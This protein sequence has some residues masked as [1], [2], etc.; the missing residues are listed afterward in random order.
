MKK[1]FILLVLSVTFIFNLFSPLALAANEE[2][3]ERDAIL[4]QLEDVAKRHNNLEIISIE[5]LPEGTPVVSFD[6]VEEFEKA[7]AEVE[8]NKKFSGA[9]EVIE[10][11]DEL[12]ENIPFENSLMTTKNGSAEIKWHE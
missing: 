7:L 4:E 3:V 1:I 11:N 8:E 10:I 9:E 5:E 2:D 12:I 6:S